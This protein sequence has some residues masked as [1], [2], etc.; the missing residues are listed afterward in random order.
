MSQVLG[1]HGEENLHKNRGNP[2]RGAIARAQN[3][4]LMQSNPAAFNA[5][6]NVQGP[7]WLPETARNCQVWAGPGPFAQPR[8]ADS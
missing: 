8:T 6:G 1:G 4:K 2:F 7:P 3:G 5:Y